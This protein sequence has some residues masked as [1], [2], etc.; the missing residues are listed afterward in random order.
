[1]NILSV[2]NLNLPSSPISNKMVIN[3]LI[4]VLICLNYINAYEEKLIKKSFQ[5]CSKKFEIITDFTHGD[6]KAGYFYQKT[7]NPIHGC[8][9]TCVK[10]FG[11]VSNQKKRTIINIIK[12]R[13]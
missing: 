8:F 11:I 5:P 2:P 12:F 3:K 7:G 9:P 1:M 6:C 13:F 10:D 4:T